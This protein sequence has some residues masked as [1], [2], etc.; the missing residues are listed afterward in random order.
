VWNMVFNRGFGPSFPWRLL[1]TAVHELFLL[2]L[3]DSAF[4][5]SPL[6]DR[7]YQ[8]CLELQ[9][10]LGGKCP[11]AAAQA[12]F[13]AL[14]SGEG[15][16]LIVSSQLRRA[17]STVVVALSDR[18]R[19][20]GEAVL[21]HSSCQEISRNFDTLSVAGPYEAPALD[22]GAEVGAK[23]D[24]SSNRGNKSLKFRGMQRVDDFAAWASKRPE[25]TIVV[26]GH[27]LWFRTFFQVFLPKNVEHIAKKRKIVNCGAV[28]FT[29]QANERNGRYRIDPDSITTVFGGFAA[30]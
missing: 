8:Q 20:S 5:D 14:A 13:S 7:G 27:S 24:A 23:L 4:I 6:S 9:T 10:F 1:K 3:A 29:L 19:R 28:A 2:P 18:L 15:T 30:K 16:T 11:D 17:V 21:L 12:D 25:K 26:G 22:Y